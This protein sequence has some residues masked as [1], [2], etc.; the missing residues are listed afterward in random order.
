[1][2]AKFF[3]VLSSAAVPNLVSNEL[4]WN[5]NKAGMFD[6]RSFY[7]A[8]NNKS[9]VLFPWKSV[10]KVKAPPRVAFFIWSAAWGKI[11]TCDNLMRIGYTMAGGVVCAN[12]SMKLWTIC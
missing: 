12:V 11:L 9:G 1:M 2:V 8:L 3:Q 6:S 7:A 5:C 10:W 4:K